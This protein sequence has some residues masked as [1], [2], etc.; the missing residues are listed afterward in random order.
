[1]PK[2]CEIICDGR[3]CIKECIEILISTKQT[4]IIQPEPSLLTTKIPSI[5]VFTSPK[6]KLESSPNSSLGF[7][8]AIILLSFFFLVTVG[9]FIF[10]PF[11]VSS[12]L[13]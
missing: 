12:H 5:Q 8:S 2:N 13:K 4:T 7:I 1:M 11:K 3:G 9:Y 6:T 10:R